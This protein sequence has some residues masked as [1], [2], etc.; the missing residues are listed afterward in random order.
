MRYPAY[1]PEVNAILDVARAADIAEDVCPDIG[2]TDII[3]HLHEAAG[4]W[5]WSFIEIIMDHEK[6]ERRHA[7]F[8]LKWRRWRN[9]RESIQRIPR[10]NAVYL[11][12][13][14]PPK[15]VKRKKRG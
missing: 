14:L 11:G 4:K 8:W 10:P 12:P 7:D 2:A 9:R 6:R 3:G 5:A 13:G 1:E 15:G